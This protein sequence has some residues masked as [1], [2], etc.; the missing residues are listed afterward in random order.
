MILLLYIFI[1]KYIFFNL[2]SQYKYMY[3][4]NII[5]LFYFY[6]LYKNVYTQTY[7]HTHTQHVYIY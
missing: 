6:K 7:T 5:K 4:S 1:N 3:L 2:F